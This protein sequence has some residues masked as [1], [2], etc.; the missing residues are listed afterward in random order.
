MGGGRLPKY[1]WMSMQTVCQGNSRP[2]QRQTAVV[3]QEK[4]VVMLRDMGEERAAD[5]M[6][7]EWTSPKEGQYTLA[8]SEGPGGR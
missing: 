7:D 3:A 1:L 2:Y 5:W 8:F 4:L 6:E